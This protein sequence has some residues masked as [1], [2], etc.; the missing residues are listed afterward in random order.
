MSGLVPIPD[1][2][3]PDLQVSSDLPDKRQGTRNTILHNSG[4]SFL[5]QLFWQEEPTVVMCD[6]RPLSTPV[7][8][9]KKTK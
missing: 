2:A 8:R 7:F 6:A 1:D 4:S 3:A 9:K 5:D